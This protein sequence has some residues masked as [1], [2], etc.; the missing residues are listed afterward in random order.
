MSEAEEIF[1]EPV[2]DT[3][4][5]MLNRAIASESL[6][7]TVQYKVTR[8]LW[9]SIG[10]L[11][12][13]FVK[14]SNS[15]KDCIEAARKDFVTESKALK[16]SMGGIRSSLDE[17]RKSNEKSSTALTRATYVLA[18]VALIQAIIFV[19]QWLK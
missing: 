6:A 11:S 13:N 3:V 9:D 5:R 8:L 15:L 7:A 1:R 12:G 18:G 2:E 4:S 17:F 10:A 14:Q 19:L 16:E